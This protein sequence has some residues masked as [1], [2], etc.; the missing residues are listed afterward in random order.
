MDYSQNTLRVL[1]TIPTDKLAALN[2]ILE[3]L[4]VVDGISAIVLGG[5][6]ARGTQHPDSDID[7]GLYYEEN[8][9]FDIDQIRQIATASGTATVTGFY[10]WGA[11]VNGGAWIST[12]HGKIDF[13]YRNVDHVRRVIHNTRKGN[14]ELDFLQ[15]PPFGFPSIIYLAETSICRPLFDPKGLVAS[16]KALVDP[17]PPGIKESI[18]QSM[19]WGCEFTLSAARGFAT[20]GDL[21]NTVGCLTRALSFLTQVLFAL[22]EIYFISDKKAIETIETFPLKPSDYTASVNR[23]LAHAG[24]NAEELSA[25]VL[26]LADL[27]HRVVDLTGGTYQPKFVLR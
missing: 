23:I 22:N 26:H 8:A 25:P 20:K 9:P 21:Y 13:L 1:Q 15:Q 4:Q 14:L 27:F 7:I 24:S 16:L 2:V 3:Q 12:N 11:W 18:T 10:E 5:S 19:L 6:Y 17:Y